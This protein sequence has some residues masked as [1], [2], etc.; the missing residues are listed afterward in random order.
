MRGGQDA[1]A[2]EELNGFLIRYFDNRDKIILAES[3]VEVD[4]PLTS[5]GEEDFGFLVN[6]PDPKGSSLSCR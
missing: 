3:G 5:P 2:K 1:P 6:R 4:N